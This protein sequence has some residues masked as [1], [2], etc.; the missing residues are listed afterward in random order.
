MKTSGPKR[1]AQ[2]LLGL[3]SLHDPKRHHIIYRGNDDDDILEIDDNNDNNNNVEKTP[4]K[5]ISFKF[6]KQ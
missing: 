1:T 4:V 6:K 3:P 2:Q 5:P